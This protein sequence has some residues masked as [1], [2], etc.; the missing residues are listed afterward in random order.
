MFR[1]RYAWVFVLLVVFITLSTVLA[2]VGVALAAP[3]GFVIPWWTVD[4]GEDSSQ[5]EECAVCGMVGQPV[6]GPLMSGEGT[7][8]IGGF[9]GGALS[10]PGSNSVYLPLMLQK[11]TC[12]LD[13]F[14]LFDLTA[15]MEPEMVNFQAH[16]Q[17]ILSALLARNPN[18]RFGLGGFQDYPYSPYGLPDDVPYERFVDLTSDTTVFQAGANQ[19]AIGNGLD[20]PEA[21]L[22]ALYQ[23]ATGAGD[24]SYIPPGLHANFRENA[25][26]LVI[27][28]TDATFQRFYSIPGASPATY[29]QAITA[30]DALGFSK[31]LGVS[32]GANSLV[33]LNSA[34]LDTGALAPSSGLD[35][36]GDGSID[37]LPNSPLV[38][39]VPS[40]GAGLSDVTL[41]LIEAAAGCE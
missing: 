41:D 37:I 28:Y 16:A 10:D 1:K 19:M 6:T 36:D 23:V 20:E 38:C 24:G 25:V 13:V 12:L 5:W 9:G 18:T 7:T 35:C 21:Q 17:N 3:D 14:F 8:V 4:G 33:D 15:S 39:S 30:I 2:I 31:I 11:D 40:N 22:P 27:L 32:S 34:A 29:P 26:K